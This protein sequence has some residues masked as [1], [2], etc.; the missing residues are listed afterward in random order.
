MSHEAVGWFKREPQ[1]HAVTRTQHAPSAAAVVRVGDGHG[2]VVGCRQ[3]WRHCLTVWAQCLFADL[4][5]DIAVLGTWDNQDPFHQAGDA[6][7]HGSGCAR[8]LSV[9]GEWVGEWVECARLCQR[10]RGSSPVFK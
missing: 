4:V 10:R 8:P 7:K 2:F 6:P 1:R 3:E 9:G 5:A